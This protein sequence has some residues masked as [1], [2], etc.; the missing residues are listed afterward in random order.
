MNEVLTPENNET[1]RSFHTAIPETLVRRVLA[2]A[3][4]EDRDVGDITTVALQ[5]YISDRLPET[6]PKTVS[7]S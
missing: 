3:A 1:R 2:V 6:G 7:D 4:L 5:Q